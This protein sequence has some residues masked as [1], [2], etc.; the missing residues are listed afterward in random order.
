VRLQIFGF[1]LVVFSNR[2][3]ALFLAQHQSEC[4]GSYTKVK[5]PEGYGKPKAKNKVSAAEASSSSS[6]TMPIEVALA[7][8]PTKGRKQEESGRHTPPAK[9]VPAATSAICVDS[10]SDGEYT[11][12][13]STAAIVVPES[14]ART[15]VQCPVCAESLADI[16]PHLDQCL[17]AQH[18]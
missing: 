10:D 16:N 7:R 13:R 18:L 6:K 5:E 9:R 12:A 14:P 1:S 4:G 2:V 15:K 11:C 3:S 17:K 8:V